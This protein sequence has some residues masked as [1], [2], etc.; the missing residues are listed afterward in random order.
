MFLRINFIGFKC[1][2][3]IKCSAILTAAAMFPF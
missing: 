3:Y 2:Q 1:F